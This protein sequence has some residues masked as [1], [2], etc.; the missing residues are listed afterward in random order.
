MHSRIR[1]PDRVSQT[2]LDDFLAAGWRCTGQAIYTSHFMRFP[3]E[4]NGRTY[5]TIPTRLHL[6]DYSFRKSLRKLYNKVHQHFKVVAGEPIVWDLEMEMVHEQYI[7]AFPD[8]RLADLERYQETPDGPFTFDTRC[9][10]VYHN[11]VLVAFSVFNL[12]ANSLYSSQGIY[13]PAWYKYSLGFF[14]MLEEIV[15]AQSTG[16]S[17]FYPGYVVPGYPMFD[18]KKR[19]GELELLLIQKDQWVPESRV[20]PDDVPFQFIKGA[21]TDLQDLLSASGVDSHLLEYSLFDIRFFDHRP[22]PFLEFP[23][24]L[25]LLAPEPARLC[26][27]VVFIPQTQQYAVVDIKF[28]G[29]G[30]HHVPTYKEIMETKPAASGIPMAIMEVISQNLD[31]NEVVGILKE[32]IGKASFF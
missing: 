19:V 30:V 16:R 23:L 15:Y 28:F 6:L 11:D 31:I 13:D 25:L 3:Q 12:G 27:I 1:Y 20:M 9:V 18:Y 8:R 24:L 14:T 22:L 2:E 21:L 4:A 17:Y 5:S 32:E 10:K 29:L 26:P 7:Q